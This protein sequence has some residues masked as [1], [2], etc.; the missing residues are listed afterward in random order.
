MA[1]ETKIGR[2]EPCP[3][4]S[5]KKF[6][7]CHGAAQSGA[8]PAFDRLSE[9][10][11]KKRIEQAKATELQRQKQQGL[12]NPIVSCLFK[13]YRIVA[14]GTR[15]YWDKQEKWQ[16][17]TDFLSFYVRKLFGQKWADVE[18]R[19]KQE[20]RH[21]LVQWY[22][23]LCEAQK[24]AFEKAGQPIYT[25][26]TGAIFAY[27][28]L[29]YNL[30]LIAHNPHLAQGQRLHARLIGRL[31]RKESFYPAFYETMVAAAFIKAGFQVELENED[32]PVED[33]AEFVALSAKTQQK[34]SVEAKHRQ[35]GKKH[36]VIRNQLYAALRKDLPY[37]RIIFIN[38]NVPGNTAEAGRVEWLDEVIR[39]MRSGEQTITVN[40]KPAPQAYVFITNHPF[41]YNL[42]SYP[43]PPAVVAEGF[44]IPDFKLDSAFMS[45]R[46]ALE[47]REKHIDMF[48]LLKAM[49]EYDEI[50]ST[51]GGEIPEYAFGE[52]TETRL[53]IGEEYPIPD[54]NGNEV[55][56]ELLDCAV[57][58]QEKKV[59]CVYKVADG[60]TSI[61]SYELSDLELQVYKRHRDTFF[62]VY[63]KQ[64]RR[65]KD[66]LELYDFFYAVYRKS[67][68]AKLLEFLKDHPGISKMK[69]MP[70]EELAKVYCET[71]VY[72]A[73]KRS[74]PRDLA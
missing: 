20:N 44:K 24:R 72:S 41:L 11:V 31:R 61:G 36:V 46:D 9:P 18:L 25:P 21:P 67:S 2:N 60:K 38:L 43:H 54:E 7:R 47:S 66:A 22:G 65:V 6:K 27:L 30:Y 51:F 33:H 8:S 4:G 23:C 35:M 5:G 68:K 37:K 58:E 45:L 42:D 63:K 48:D 17:F 70:Q 59:Y 69:E 3:C 39:P 49:R 14:V 12:G 16:S 26:V 34:Y 10:E 32:D 13:G 73:L 53:K 15:L 62:G 1:K 28:T 74:S 56:A 29:A 71:L 57:S 50:P 19:K 52:I 40:G 64:D 55:V